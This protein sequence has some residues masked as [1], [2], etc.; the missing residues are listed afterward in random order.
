MP[1]ESIARNSL[2]SMSSFDGLN[3]H[4]E[5]LSS[6]KSTV[7][8]FA[9]SVALKSAET[10]RVVHDAPSALRNWRVSPDDVSGTSAC[11]LESV[12]AASWQLKI[13]LMRSPRPH[14]TGAVY[15]QVSSDRGSLRTS[16]SAPP[17]DCGGASDTTY[18]FYASGIGASCVPL[19]KRL[20]FAI[21]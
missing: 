2:P 4:S 6:A 10:I 5:P 9:K 20:A 21:R 3:V 16:T 12:T 13:S 7:N 18:E 15:F 11:P 19:R 1:V 8:P 14:T 17:C